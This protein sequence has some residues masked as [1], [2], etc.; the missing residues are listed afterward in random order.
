MKILDRRGRLFGKV[1]IVDLFV[2]LIVVALACAL[3]YKK[4]SKSVNSSA[5]GANAPDEYCY[6]TLYCNQMVPEFSKSINIGDHMVANGKFTDA[7]VVA[8]NEEPAAYVGYDDN[9][10]AVLSQHPLWKDVTVVIKE[11]ISPNPVIRKVGEQE[12]RVGYQYIFKTQK[13]ESGAKV[14]RVEFESELS[15]DTVN[16]LESGKVPESYLLPKNGDAAPA[17]PAEEQTQPVNAE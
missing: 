14:R 12:V 11:K 5:D 4:T 15:A 7:T 17:A 13:V 1:N 6:V 16:K 3:I 9:G 2:V 8:V 10:K